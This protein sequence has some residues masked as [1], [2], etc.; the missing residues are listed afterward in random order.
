MSK[1]EAR[2][3]IMSITPYAPPK[4]IEEIQK[5]FGLKEVIKLAFN[6]N[7]L[8]SSPKALEAM[9]SELERAHMYPDGGS[10]ELR[11]ALANK[12]GIEASQIVVGN[13]G[14]HVISLVAEAFVNEGDEVIVADPSFAT[15]QFA[16][17]IAG[18]R[19]I[20]VP[21]DK[22]TLAPDLA[23]LTAAVTERSKVI[24]LCN[25][26]NPTS[27]IVRRREVEAFLA[28]V[29]GHCLVVFDEAYFEYVDDPEYPSGLDYVKQGKSVL[30]IRTFSKAYGLAGLRIGYAMGPKAIMDILARTAPPFPVNRVAQAGALAALQ[31]ADFVARVVKENSAGRSYL[32]AEFDK[33]GLTYAEAQANFIFVDMKRDAA[34]LNGEL[35]KRGF[36]LRPAGSWGYP[37][38]FRISVGS[39]DE[40]EKFIS[41]LRDL[42]R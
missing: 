41:A 5:E 33:L 3:G 4:S 42:I 27:A 26:N 10:L 8:K 32:C 29:P 25:P 16:S 37:S 1:I 17:T 19:L 22:K 14:D 21:V 39:R 2:R 35:L 7:P 28:K 24:F 20:S 34:D 11:S 12:Y 9:R 15:Y 38:F 6:E 30:V 23:G 18:G 31:D 13:G 40:N 36:I